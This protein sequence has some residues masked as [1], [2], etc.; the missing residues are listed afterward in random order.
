MA[1]SAGLSGVFE[2]GPV[3]RAEPSFTSRH[4]TEFTGIDAE[5]GW[6]DGFDDV[7]TFQ[8]GMLR[9][10]LAK[11]AD[12][13]SEAIKQHFGVDV[14]VPSVPFPRMT[15]AEAQ[16][17]LRA[18]GWQPFGDRHDDLD[19]EGERG[20]GAYIREQAGHEFVFVTEFP[21]SSRPFYHMRETGRPE[22]TLSADLLWKG[23][24]ITTG[25][26]REHRYAVLLDQA[27][28]KDIDTASI[29]DYLNCFRYGCPPHGGFGMG[30]GRVLL[31]MLGLESI[32]EAVFLFRGPN[33]LTP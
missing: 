13:H 24:E 7:M 9:H 16:K 14:V 18:R 22:L 3:F 2:I 27:A 10:A 32:R 19:N 33:R 30:L 20:V 23:M 6:I 26:Q 25:A 17:M 29:Q 12:A 15:M 8:E 11:V 4:S 31:Q 21:A 1:I 28:E 5:L